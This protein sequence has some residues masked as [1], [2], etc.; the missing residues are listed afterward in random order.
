[1]KA[2]TCKQEKPVIIK[3]FNI[4]KNL[5]HAKLALPRLRLTGTLVTIRGLDFCCVVCTCVS[6]WTPVAH[7]KRNTTLSLMWTLT[8]YKGRGN[9]C[10]DQYRNP[11]VSLA[12]ISKFA[13]QQQRKI[14]IHNITITGV[15]SGVPGGDASPR[16][17]DESTCTYDIKKQVNRADENHD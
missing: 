12:S 8:R 6:G 13:G 3:A 17:V 7:H 5:K 9:R 11:N 1:M 10:N 14:S 16:A 15:C 2:L 4:F